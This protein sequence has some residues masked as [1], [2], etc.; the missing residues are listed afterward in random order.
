MLAEAAAFWT[1]RADGPCG[2]APRLAN[3]E[4][5][6]D[7]DA[8]KLLRVMTQ[9]RRELAAWRADVLRATDG[10]DAD[11][12]PRVRHKLRP[13]A[14]LF[15]MT[16]TAGALAGDAADAPM[17]LRTMACCDRALLLRQAQL[18]ATA[19]AAGG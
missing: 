5:Q 14:V 17:L 16:A 18:A 12:L 3:L 1:G 9:Y 2:E 13:H 19:G 8:E 7:R 11:V 10:G 6:Y 15:G 4:D